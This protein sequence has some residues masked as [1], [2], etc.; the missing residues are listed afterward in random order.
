MSQPRASPPG[1]ADPPP[2]TPPGRPTCP[3]LPGAVSGSCSGAA[4]KKVV[5]QLRLE[6]GLNRVKLS[7]AAA[8]VKQFCLQNAQHEPLLTGVSS[9][10]NPFRA[11]KVCSFLASGFLNHFS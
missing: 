10:R 5:Q 9:S 6:A 11:Q 4:A 2:P 7:Q 8:D 1:P 3:A